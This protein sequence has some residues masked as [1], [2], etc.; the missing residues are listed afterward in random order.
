MSPRLQIASF[1]LHHTRR[2]DRAL[3][4]AQAEPRI[5]EA[6]LLALQETDQAAAERFAAVLGLSHV[7][8]HGEVHPHTGR[9]FGPA[10]LSRWPVG[11]SCRVDLP[12][13]G[14]H[15]LARLAVAATVLVEGTPV[16]TYAVHLGTMR[17]IL[18]AHQNAQARALLAH[19]AAGTERAV[20]AGD[21]NR[22]GIGRLFEAAGWRWVTRDVGPT[23]HCWSFDHVFVRGWDGAATRSG[24]VRA[25]LAASDHRAV[26]AEVG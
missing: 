17:E 13:P 15:G 19:A 12:H 22:K 3:Q 7:C 4:V 10:L 5:R 2:L 24:S 26:W 6:D 1:N 25:A 8:Y 14:L 9:C 23:H 21:L 20:V 18:P 16:R 11:D